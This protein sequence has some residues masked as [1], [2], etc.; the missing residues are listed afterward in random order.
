MSEE[1]GFSAA[2]R[3]EGHLF[4]SGQIG[5]ADDG[6]VP[7]DPATQYALAFAALEKVLATEGC[8]A[9]DIVDLTSF[10]THYPSHMDVFM[11]QKAK[12]L[13]TVRPAWTAIGVA[14][15]GFPESLVEIK[16]IAKIRR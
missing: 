12:F 10:H 4:C 7:E 5:I 1:Y 9:A 14:A 2:V 13:G 15:L 6:T 8:T 3:S 16:A 11:E